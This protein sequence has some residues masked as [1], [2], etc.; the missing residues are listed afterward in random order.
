MEIFKSKAT[1]SWLL[2]SL[3]FS[4]DGVKTP[5]HDKLEVDVHFGSPVFID[6]MKN[7]SESFIREYHINNSF[8]EVTIERKGIE[9]V[10]ITL[11]CR[12]LFYFQS[13]GLHPLFTYQIN[14]NTFFVIIG[15]EP[16]FNISS[17]DGKFSERKSEG[18]Y[19]S[20]RACF[21]Y[22]DGKIKREEKCTYPFPFSDFQWSEPPVN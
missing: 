11:T 13:Q 17:Y 2:I 4:C 21:W 18:C 10:Y 15:V 5:T 20:P 19:E 1:L 6:E 14:N 16:L 3:F 22:R 7:I 8:I 12:G 9:G